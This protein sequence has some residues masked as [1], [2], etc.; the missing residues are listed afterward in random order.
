MVV[1]NSVHFAQPDFWLVTGN[2]I[3][4][5]HFSA[6][7]IEAPGGLKMDLKSG[8]KFGDRYQLLSKPGEGG[9]GKAWKERDAR[10]LLNTE[11]DDPSTEPIHLML[12]WRPPRK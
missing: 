7:L 9:M 10:F 11:P 5:D 6:T 1:R 4:C 8:D 12:K 3:T 2:R